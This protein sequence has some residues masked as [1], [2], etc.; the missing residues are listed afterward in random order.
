LGV[1]KGVFDIEGNVVTCG[2]F[3]TRNM[4][5]LNRNDGKRLSYGEGKPAWAYGKGWPWTP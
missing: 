1:K 5:E 4:V 3:K 2:T